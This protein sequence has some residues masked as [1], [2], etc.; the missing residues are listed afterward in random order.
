[1]N[2]STWY[3]HKI[4]LDDGAVISIICTE[5]ISYGYEDKLF[6]CALIN[7]NGE[8]DHDSVT[9]NLGFHQVA[10]YI[11]KAMEKHNEQITETSKP[12]EK[13]RGIYIFG[14]TNYKDY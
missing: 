9:G 3:Q 7:P 4:K 14:V 11:D 13:S 12:T 2:K 1:M 8:I 10:E 6:E 5:G